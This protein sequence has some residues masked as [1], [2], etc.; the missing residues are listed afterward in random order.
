MFRAIYLL[1]GIALWA[2]AS[3][4][5]ALANEAGIACTDRD[6]AVTH[7]SSKYR[8]HTV[9]LGLASN[10][11]VLEL[12]TDEAGK[13]WSIIVTTPD[14]LSC[15]VANGEYWEPVQPIKAGSRI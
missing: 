7:L 13:T 8:E 4:N 6:S 14:G 3:A 15:M 12:L 9:A 1:A 11:G 2:S 5:T 10:G